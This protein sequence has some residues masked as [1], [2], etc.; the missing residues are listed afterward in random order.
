MN[1]EMAYHENRMYSWQ[2][3]GMLHQY[4]KQMCLGA[5]AGVSCSKI[6]QDL[7]TKY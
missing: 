6:L 4:V 1:M 5:Y 2:D 3:S 7:V